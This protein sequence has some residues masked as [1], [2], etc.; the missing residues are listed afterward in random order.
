MDDSMSGSTREQFDAAKAENKELMAQLNAAQSK[1][2][3][4]AEERLG[5][6]AALGKMLRMINAT[7]NYPLIDAAYEI[8]EKCEADAKAIMDKLDPVQRDGGESKSDK[9]KPACQLEDNLMKYRDK[10][11]QIK[12]DLK[13]RAAYYEAECK[14][15]QDW[16]KVMNQVVE[17]TK[18]KAK[19]DAPLVERVEEAA[20]AAAVVF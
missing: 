20:K 12:K 15:K 13:N 3:N 7:E 6:Q 18:E 8:S 16:E 5:V 1:Y 2:M 9:E 17:L 11:V 14:I 10:N 4:K 19:K